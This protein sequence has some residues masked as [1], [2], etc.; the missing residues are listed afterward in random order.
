VKKD[1][2]QQAIEGMSGYFRKAGM[3]EERN[4]CTL[5]EARL[6]RLKIDQ[7]KGILT[8]DRLATETAR[9]RHAILNLAEEMG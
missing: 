6:N 7:D 2:L 1:K 8:E 3:D 9:I 5:L 4:T